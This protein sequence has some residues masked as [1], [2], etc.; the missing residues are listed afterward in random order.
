L[1][2]ERRSATFSLWEDFVPGRAA[3]A[4]KATG[5]TEE[6][7]ARPLRWGVAQRPRAFV[8]CFAQATGLF[9]PTW[10]ASQRAIAVLGRCD[11]LAGQARRT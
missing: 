5:T 10:R 7:D 4:R 9:G 11:F 1:P 3:A 2:V 6:A 8:R